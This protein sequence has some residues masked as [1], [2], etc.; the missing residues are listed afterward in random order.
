MITKDSERVWDNVHT[1]PD[2][3]YPNE[4]IVRFLAKY[5]RKRTGLTTYQV[6]RADITRILDVGCG[7]GAHLVMLAREGYQ[8]YGID[9]SPRAIAFAKSW[10]A[11]ERLSAD[12]RIGSATE[13]PWETGSLDAAIAHGVLDHMRWENAQETAQEVA[14]VLKPSGLFYLS[15]VSTN[16]SGFGQGQAIDPYTYVVPDGVEGGT[17]Q[18]FFER[19]HIIEL[20]GGAFEILDIVYDEWQA[21]Y[22]R[23]FSAL[24]KQNYPKFARFHIAAQRR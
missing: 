12:A 15:L 22:G 7:H 6:H 2:G 4:F 18:R 9:L 17:V 24:D 16:E 11:H 5:V 3:W 19:P 13:L 1:V 14:R 10:L 8:T 20:L 23:G 21:V